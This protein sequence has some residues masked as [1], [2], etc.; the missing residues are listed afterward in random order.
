MGDQLSSS[1][2]GLA[3]VYVGQGSMGAAALAALLDGMAA[4]AM[5]R[6]VLSAEPAWGV[7]PVAATAEARSQPVVHV[8]AIGD[9]PAARW[10]ELFESLD[11]AVIGCW[12]E[13]IT[14]RAL[15][16]P[17]LGWLNLHPSALPSWRGFDPVAWQLLTAPS[18]VGC[19]VHRVTEG[20]DDGPVLAQ[21]SVPV[22][23]GDDR[24][25]VLSRAGARLGELAGDVLTSMAS[26]ARVPER[27]QPPEAV[28]W[29]PPAGVVPM[30]DPRQL[31]A[32][33]G[34]RVARAFSPQPGVALSTMAGQ[35]RFAV[36]DV[37]PAL[38]D[39]DAPGAVQAIEGDGEANVAVA[40]RD[41][42]V[43]GR[44]W[45]LDASQPSLTSLGP[46]EPKPQ[47]GRPPRS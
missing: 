40:F 23:P 19:T 28:T 3:W 17:A 10:P 13:R 37:G 46:L 38:G 5:P 21:G 41:R 24:E 44:T 20:Q 31:G 26:G 47:A 43:R 7:R 9:D 15:E 22:E 36:V 6:A 32:A 2:P 16:A 30:L 12:I 14:R 4:V 45:A 11:I 29:C 34:A 27:V 42:W 1:S 35:Q 25:A 8:D 33:A 18:V 39:G